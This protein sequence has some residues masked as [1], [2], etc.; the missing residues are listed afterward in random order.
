MKQ[1]D[2]VKSYCMSSIAFIFSDWVKDS[3]FN[4]F[5]YLLTFNSATNIIKG[6]IVPAV[7]N[8]TETSTI[9]PKTMEEVNKVDEAEL[10]EL[11]EE[12]TEK[13]K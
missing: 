6:L 10:I 4:R 12:V 7:T 13:T 3:H 5:L 9:T 11:A 2:A 8:G 1:I